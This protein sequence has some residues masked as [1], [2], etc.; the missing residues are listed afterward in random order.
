MA[1]DAESIGSLLSST[2]SRSEHMAYYKGELGLDHP[3]ATMLYRGERLQE[4]GQLKQALQYFNKV[5]SNAPDCTEAAENARMVKQTLEEER[6]TTP[7]LASISEAKP[8]YTTTEMQVEWHSYEDYRFDVYP[9]P[10]GAAFAEAKYQLMETGHENSLLKLVKNEIL[11][12]VCNHETDWQQCMRGRATFQVTLIK[13]DAERSEEHEASADAAL[14]NLLRQIRTLSPQVNTPLE[15][16]Q[17][18]ATTPAMSSSMD[19]RSEP[20]EE[21]VAQPDGSFAPR[22]PSPASSHTPSEIMA[23]A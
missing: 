15:T 13:N 10:D 19:S 20:P 6:A 12:D 22:A 21:F 2:S 5:L 3:T 4:K 7:A 17:A 23:A 11:E 9:E 1:D 18:Y 8:E 16:A 14:A